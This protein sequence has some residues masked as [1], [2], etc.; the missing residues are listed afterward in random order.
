MV[1]YGEEVWPTYICDWSESLQKRFGRQRRGMGSGFVGAN[2]GLGFGWWRRALGVGSVLDDEECF[3]RRWR[4]DR[5][6]CIGWQRSGMGKEKGNKRNRKSEF[7]FLYYWVLER[8]KKSEF[9]F[10]LSNADMENCKEIRGFGF[11][12]II[13]LCSCDV[14]LNK[15]YFDNINKLNNK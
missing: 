15:K 10:F 4:F 6:A 2:M 14:R 5:E 11:I 8:K 1:W 13:V 12:Y 7:S 3:G 9:L